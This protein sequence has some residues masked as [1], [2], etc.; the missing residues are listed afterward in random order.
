[1]SDLVHGGSASST[2]E[3]AAELEAAMSALARALGDAAGQ[4]RGAL[5]ITE[6]V[7]AVHEMRK[8]FK[9][10]R[11]LLRLVRHA[12]GREER[13]AAR[14]LGRALGTAAGRLS[15]TRDA[16]ARREALDDLVEQELIAPAVRGAASRALAPR[17]A[18]GQ[19]AGLGRHRAELS[20]LIEACATGARDLAGPLGLR[21]MLDAMTVEYA[22]ARRLGGRVDAADPESLH[23]LRKAVVAHRYQMELASEAWPAMGTF[24]VNELQKLRDRLGTHHDHAV[25]LH[26]LQALPPRRASRAESSESQPTTQ[27]AWRAALAA[28]IE[29]RQAKLVRTGMRQHAR[30]F[31]ETPKAFR[32]R[33]AA[34]FDPV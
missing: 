9:R 33:L 7:Q 14:G 18:D 6:P 16:A 26:D 2:P 1:M 17:G 4:A 20:A 24:W 11:A 13:A 8:A 29:I 30:L 23:A 31:A 21:R 22:R 10:L 12:G 28:S 3:S 32:R 19:E 5:D 25:L 34:Y 27:P 15:V